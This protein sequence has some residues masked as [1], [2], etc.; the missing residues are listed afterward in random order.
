MSP[1]RRLLTSL[2][3]AAAHG[4][5]LSFVRALRPRHAPDRRFEARRRRDLR[6]ITRWLLVVQIAYQGLSA[7]TTRPGTVA[8]D[9]PTALV[10]GLA[11]FCI[12][13]VLFWMTGRVKST[14]VLEAVGVVGASLALVSSFVGVLLDPQAGP[15]EFVGKYVLAIVVLALAVPWRIRTHQLWLVCMTGLFWVGLQL[16]INAGGSRGVTVGSLA[17][18]L[19]ISAFGKVLAW[20]VR[21][22]RYF[23]HAQ[24]RRLNAALRA[25]SLGDPA[26]GVGN[27]QALEGHLTRL[28]VRSGGTVGFA[29]VDV[30]HFKLVNDAFGHLAGDDVLRKVV[31][32][33]SAATRGSDRV[34]R[35]G[36]EEFLVVIDRTD[37][38][39][40]PLVAERIR[41]GVEARALPNPGASPGI[42]TVSVGTAEITLP[43]SRGSIVEAIAVADVRL[44]IAKQGG[45][46]AVVTC[47]S[48]PVDGSQSLA[49]PAP[50][51][52]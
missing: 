11:F 37:R 34:F 26:T 31:Q 46:N 33:I 13:V 12:S 40:A 48:P 3:T 30:D 7:V 16:S 21:V 9:Q 17:F 45:R 43:A 6:E 29:L 19:L 28:A 41:A 15:A 25:S 32:A 4:P 44:Y 50:S 51:I 10:L 27:R 49:S 47:D 36:G 1:V 39:A 22:D 18:L 42:V 38:D 35:Y 23:E 2:A 14:T 8:P 20:N 24:I 5:A 52:R